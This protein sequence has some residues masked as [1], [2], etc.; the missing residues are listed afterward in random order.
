M[1]KRKFYIIKTILFALS[2]V[3]IYYFV[4]FIIEKGIYDVLSE[5][6]VITTYSSKYYDA[7]MKE[8]V[9]KLFE[10]RIYVKE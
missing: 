2:V 5:E 6:G 4:L 7:T 1:T 8:V 3:S 10:S 9:S